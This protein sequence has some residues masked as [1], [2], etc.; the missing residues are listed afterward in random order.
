MV[1]R[2]HVLVCA[3]AGCISS[4][5]RAVQ[6][7]LVTAI[8]EHGLAE[9]V[10]VVE[11]GCMGPC[12][13]G[14]VVVVYPEGVF[15]QKLRPEDA[16]SIVD[17]HLLKGR[18][19]DR[20]VH[21]L[22][23]TLESLPTFDEIPF[24]SRQTRVALRNT[25]LIDPE[26]IEEYIA[27]D[28]YAAL[29]KVL[30]SMSPEEVVAA[31]K[32]SGLR[33]RGGAGFAT[34]L[35]WEFTARAQGSPK[36]V[37]C[38]ADEG[39]PGAFMDRSVLEGDPHSVLEAMAICGY[40][41][42]SSQ[43]YVYVRAEYPL[44]VDRL[45]LA[46]RQAREYGLL[47]KNIFGSSFSF[48][49]DIR[50]G[51]GAFVCGEETALLASIEGRRGEPRPRPP[52]P[53]QQGLWG[54]PTVL[55]NVETWANIPPIILQG[56]EWFASVG[57]EKARGTKVFA[58][59]GKVVNTGLVEVPLGTPIG[60]IIYD[61][62][63]GVPKG[64]SLKAAQTGGPSGGCIPRQFLNV[65]VDYESL[66]ELGTIMGS[67]GLIVVDED[68][69][70]VD[71]AKFFIEFC[72][73]ESCG[74]CAPC[75][76][77]MTRMQEILD[78]ITKGRGR[79][80][81]VELLVEL[82][83]HI[84]ATALCGLGQTAPNPVLS[85]IRYFREEYDAHIRDRRCAASVCATMFASPCQNTCPVD[86]DVPVY[87]DHIA[88]GRYL[89]AYQAVM[90]D[91]P[92]P[93]ICGRVCHHPCEGKC[94][95]A[96]LDQ[97]LAIR[98]LKRF[99]A[100]QA[101]K[102]NGELPRPSP[103]I[104]K[105]EKVAVVGSGP[106]G[107]TAAYYL[108]RKGYPVTVFESLPVAGG[109]LAMGI[110]DYRLPRDVLK[111]EVHRIESAGV[112]IKTNTRI[113]KDITIDGLHR[114]GF[115][116][117]FIAVG[118]HRGQKLGVPGEELEGVLGGVEFLREL[119]LGR[120]ADLGRKKVAVIGGG[121]AAVDAARSALRLGAGEVHL[122]YRRTR[123]EMPAERDEIDEA[124]REGVRLHLLVAPAEI[125]GEGGKVRRLLCQRMK[126]G[127]FDST[128]RRR[129]IADQGAHLELDVD[130]VI[131]A[132][133]QAV[134]TS[135]TAGHESL[136]DGGRIKVLNG[137]PGTGLPWLFAGGDCVTGPDT[138]VE[139]IA[140]GKRA[141]SAIDRHLGGDGVIVKRAAVARV[142][143]EILEEE[144]PRVPVPMVP[145]E[146]RKSFEQVELG[147]KPDQ[148]VAEARR[149]LRCDVREVVEEGAG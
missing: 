4:G 38:N 148:A 119:N 45:G 146:K 134:D 46:I 66:T 120:S 23:G 35:K 97:P 65:P 135:V 105:S 138:V 76:L 34:G 114:Q 94:R 88:N 81:D 69:C 3:G 1:H 103:S 37:V 128:G 129:P 121:N 2:A 109:M 143:G 73:E 137:G 101:L 56:P 40:A 104:A 125:A 131:A 71:L 59:A 86:I 130:I 147:Y 67:G 21:R 139:A 20:L 117:V 31:V 17:E 16:I 64:K 51:A 85:T 12:D 123:E 18:I 49:V 102:L 10:Q 89:E 133:G 115:S 87:L 112:R 22:P 42:G 25:G 58:L 140:A 74:K 90:A 52:F 24:F 62:G 82:G 15:Y 41:V 26:R 68:T 48:D 98:A 14:P 19:V 91:N 5:C 113:G 127:E 110:P 96:Q 70:M 83:E 141:A 28:G 78:R 142:A 149:C 108:A 118:A 9:E 7:A 33:G 63:G 27:R 54:K 43:G 30:S 8:G 57:T 36:Y 44:A 11:T 80:G 111:A 144:T 126:L 124:E 107:L 99:A 61:I 53:A 72:Q 92:F 136:A 132:I 93:S 6:E 145:V 55:N 84:K 39:D 60:E 29:G 122:V 95:R 106:A 32:A 116:A 79:E 47:G 50:V 13:L 75:R 77:G 100:D